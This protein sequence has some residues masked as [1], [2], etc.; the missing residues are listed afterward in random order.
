MKQ[1]NGRVAVV[2]GAGSGIGRAVSLELARR[3]VDI[4]LVDIDEARLLDVKA[5]IDAP[6]QSRWG[7]APPI[8]IKQAVLIALRQ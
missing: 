7:Q 3:G 5:A 2:T 1:I 6:G 8:D 4:A